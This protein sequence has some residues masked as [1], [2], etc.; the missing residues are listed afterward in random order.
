MSDWMPERISVNGHVYVREDV[1][2]REGTLE[3]HIGVRALSELSGK[4]MRT[5]YDAIERGELRAKLPNGKRRGMVVSESEAQRWL[6][7]QSS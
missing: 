5:I 2:R 6:S 4:P 3:R 7:G 1:R